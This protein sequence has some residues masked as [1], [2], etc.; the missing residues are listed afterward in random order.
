MGGAE[1][2]VNRPKPDPEKMQVLRSLPIEIKEK[3]TKEEVDA[4]LYEDIWPDSLYE[5]LKPLMDDEGLS[6][7]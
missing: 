3:L 5:K 4:F 2:T 7:S 6:Q 1:S